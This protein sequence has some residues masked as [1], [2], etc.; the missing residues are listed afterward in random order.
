MKPESVLRL[1]TALFIVNLIVTSLQVHWG[2]WGAA[3]FGALLTLTW[4][5]EMKP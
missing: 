1:R 4:W 2:N 3:T 5:Q